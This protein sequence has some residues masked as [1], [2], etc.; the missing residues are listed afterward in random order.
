[1]VQF[2]SFRFV[3]EED[4]GTYDVDLVISEAAGVNV[5]VPY[6]ITG[7]ASG[8]SD[9]S[10]PA[11]PAVVP[12]GSTSGAIP[13]TV[14]L[15]AEFEPGEVFLVSLG[16]PDNALPGAIDSHLVLI[17]EVEDAVSG[18]LSDPLV[19]STPTVDFPQVRV[20]EVT[21][22]QTVQFANVSPRSVTVTS[23]AP[24][25]PAAGDFVADVV[26][27]LPAVVGPG[28]NLTV[29]FTFEPQTYGQR[30]STV[31]AALTFSGASPVPVA[32]RGLALGAP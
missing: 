20:G 19:P 30:T 23:V 17:A 24:A 3:V 1:T 14:V 8:P 22:P 31:G 27:G 4:V 16:A 7:R 6:T 5:T 32:L 13:I 2:T 26:G 25:G 15:D 29:D 10:Y 12:A 28:Q 18:A 9:I 21:A 11:G